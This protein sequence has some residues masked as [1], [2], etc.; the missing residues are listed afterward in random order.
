M[1]RQEHQPADISRMRHWVCRVGGTDGPAA[2]VGAHRLVTEYGCA[3]VVLVH[4]R[5]KWRRS[6]HE[7][8]GKLADGGPLGA[9]VAGNQA[10]RSALVHEVD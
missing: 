4:R 10:G 6:T 2:R 9:A 7:G 1:T 3:M 5:P 8:A